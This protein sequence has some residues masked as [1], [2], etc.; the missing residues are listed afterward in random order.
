MI[1]HLQVGDQLCNYGYR[2]PK[3]VDIL[4]L[5]LKKPLSRIFGLVKNPEEATASSDNIQWITEFQAR[6]TYWNL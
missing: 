1:V 2:Q 5:E 6:R 4:S 3:K